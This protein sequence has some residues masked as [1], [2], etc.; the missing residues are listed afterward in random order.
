M[1]GT[2]RDRPTLKGRRVVPNR[3]FLAYPWERYRK[4]YEEV[5]NEMHR[6]FP[7]YFFA[8]GR[9]RGTRAEDLYQRIKKV[10]SASTFALFDASKGNPNVSLEYGY[11]DA[12][13]GLERFLL[14]DEYTIPSRSSAGTPII[15]DL[16][17]LT[18][19]RWQIDDLSTLRTHLEAIAERHPYTVRF[20]NF[21]R[22][23]GYRGGSIRAFLKIIR[24]F[25]ER[26]ELLRRELLDE[27]G[28][29]PGAPGRAILE[30]R[31]RTLHESGLVTVTRGNLASSRVWIS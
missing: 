24:K 20:R 7:V 31:L 26:E 6:R 12:L 15:A 5:C 25:D 2:R 16:A 9:P 29:E 4:H 13:D 17:G 8:L 30:Q 27:L 11:A 18:Q 22:R 10:V 1:A 21:T 28:T 19:N 3:I 14:I 23:H